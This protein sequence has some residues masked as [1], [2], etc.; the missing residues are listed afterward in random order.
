MA[1]FF[2]LF[3]DLNVTTVRAAVRVSLAHQDHLPRV[4]IPKTPCKDKTRQMTAFL[5]QREAIWAEKATIRTEDKGTKPSHP[6]NTRMK[7]LFQLRQMRGFQR[8]HNRQKPRKGSSQV[9]WH[10]EK[11]AYQSASLSARGMLPAIAG[12]PLCTG[13]NLM[14]RHTLRTSVEQSGK[15]APHMWAFHGA[16]G[17]S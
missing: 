17:K 1:F 6:I 7:K 11:S 13:T 4:L 12:L 2:F 5:R 16:N 9:F 10:C 3:N 8:G 15:H 14:K